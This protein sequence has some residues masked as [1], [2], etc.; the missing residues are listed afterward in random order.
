MAPGEGN[1]TLSGGWPASTSWSSRGSAM[2]ESASRSWPTRTGSSRSTSRRSLARMPTAAYRWWAGTAAA[3][4]C[5]W[6]QGWRAACCGGDELD[7]G[8]NG[9]F[10]VDYPEQGTPEEFAAAI[11]DWL[12]NIT[13]DFW[14]ALVLEPLDPDGTLDDRGREAW[15]D[16]ED[17]MLTVS[18]VLR[19]AEGIEPLLR[20]ALTRISDSYVRSAEARANP[21]GHVAQ[22]MLA[23]DQPDLYYGEWTGQL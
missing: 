11:A 21:A 5:C 18:P 10:L 3:T 15:A 9:F 14:A 4:L 17:G 13:F 16:F 12:T 7:S 19:V 6:V 2:P 22:V 23:S 20:G 1:C 8:D